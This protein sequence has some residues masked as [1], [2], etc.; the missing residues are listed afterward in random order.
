M[1]DDGNKLDPRQ[2]RH[3][4]AVEW[5]RDQQAEKRGGK[6]PRQVLDATGDAHLVAQRTQDIVAGKQCKEIREGP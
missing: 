4:R 2:S 6:E 1:V 5:L 3:Q